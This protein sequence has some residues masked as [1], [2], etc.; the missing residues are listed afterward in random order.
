MPIFHPAID[1][2]TL[3][4]LIPQMAPEWGIT[5]IAGDPYVG[6]TRLALHM[7]GAFGEGKPLLGESP[8]VR[9]VLFFSERPAASIRRQLK[10]HNLHL[11]ETVIFVSLPSLL[12]ED[13]ASHFRNMSDWVKGVLN[14]Y[15]ADVVF[16]DTFNHFL[17]RN[18]KGKGALND[19]GLMAEALLE[20]TRIALVHK[21]SIFLI[22]HNVKQKEGEG[23]RDFKLKSSGSAAILGNTL[24]MWGFSQYQEYLKLEI[25]YHHAGPVDPIFLKVLKDGSLGIVDQKEVLLISGDKRTDQLYSLLSAEPMAKAEVIKL[26]ESYLR[27][28]RTHAY[29]TLRTLCEESRA[30]EFKAEEGVMIQRI[31]S[32]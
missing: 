18:S 4:D 28:S 20:F 7:A 3:V 5:L 22:H 19:Y 26:A 23:Y 24:A 8:T 27:V 2:H 10:D 16:F 15:K 13:R 30:K 17:P 25:A 32:H 11:P 21:V 6:K 1:S 12:E 31:E 29:N 14:K 9:K